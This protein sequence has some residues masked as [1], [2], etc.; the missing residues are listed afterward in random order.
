MNRVTYFAALWL[1][2]QRSEG[3]KLKAETTMSRTSGGL[4]S[5]KLYNIG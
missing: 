5:R 2:I 3:R 1:F 4:K